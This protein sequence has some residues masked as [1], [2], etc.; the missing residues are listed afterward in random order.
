MP[1]GRRPDVL[2]EAVVA[3]AGGDGGLRSEPRFADE[4]EDGA[5]VVVD[6]AHEQWC[7]R[8]RDA[9]RR[10]VLGAIGPVEFRLT[11]PHLPT[12]GDLLDAARSAYGSTFAAVVERSRVWVN[13]AEPADGPHTALPDGD[14]VAVLP[15]VSGG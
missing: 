11:S 6:A 9:E 7:R 14:E 12:V 5:R 2:E 10:Q 3:T 15:P 1:P 13:G 8:D 4:F